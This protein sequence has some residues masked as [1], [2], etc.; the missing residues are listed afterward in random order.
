[1]P[2]SL[3]HALR[4]EFEELE[5]NNL[6]RRLREPSGLDLCSNDYLGLAAHPVVARRMADAA[7]SLGAGSTGSRLL[8]GERTV[9]SALERRFAA[10]KGTERAL[11]FSSGYLANL[12]LLTALARP[13]DVVFSDERNHASLI[14]GI[15]LARAQCVIFPHNDPDRLAALIK[16]TP[17]PHRGFLVTES[18]FSMDGDVA[19]LGAYAAICRRHNLTLIVDEAHAVGVCGESG[20]G[21]LEYVDATGVPV[22]SVNTAGKALGVCG[23]FV[24]GPGWAIEHL[25]QR[26]RPFI[27]STAPPPSLAAA[28]DASLELVEAE[29]ER[30]QRLAENV[31][32]LAE[33]LT[34]IGLPVARPA[35]HIVP[36]LLGSNARALGVALDLQARGFDARA[37]RPPTVPDGTARLRISVNVRLSA[38]DIGRFVAALQDVIAEH[39]R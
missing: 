7:L 28:L 37:I 30:R 17:I 12:G 38:R 34:K 31:S 2:E 27:F 22:I 16:T 18:L 32:C 14:D 11:F 20:S 35:S 23:A 25:V 4:R 33:A 8:R 15:R 9:F 3:E 36:I 10:F 19:P 13:T 26:A 1:M 21:L 29:P 39:V 24:A 5:R 6:L